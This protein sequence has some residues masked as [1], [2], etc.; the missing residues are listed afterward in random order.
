M[1]LSERLVT[2]A[3]QILEGDTSIEAARRL[4]AVVLDDHPGDERLEE[5]VYVLSMYA[6]GAGSTYFDAE[7]LREVVKQALRSCNEQAD[8][9]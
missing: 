9:G 4:E 1:I 6:P 3:R 7:D 2:A 8:K 5:L